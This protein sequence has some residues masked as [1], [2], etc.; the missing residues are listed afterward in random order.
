MKGTRYALLGLALATALCW[1]LPV[2]PNDTVLL[3]GTME[4]GV[5]VPPKANP[6]E[7]LGAESAAH[8]GVVDEVRHCCSVGCSGRPIRGLP[9]PFLAVPP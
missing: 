9:L 1:A 6:G 8:T 3:M 2:I 4:D 7:N 5:I